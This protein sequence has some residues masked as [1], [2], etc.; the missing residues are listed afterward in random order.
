[1]RTLTVEEAD[2]V[3]GGWLHVMPGESW[4]DPQS[5][6]AASNANCAGTAGLTGV[7]AGMGVAAIAI[8]TTPVG[9]AVA[10]V[11][12]FLGLFFGSVATAGA[13]MPEPKSEKKAK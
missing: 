4:G 10:T 1:M 5:L 3:S 7:T 8:A 2:F 11:G 12:T 6:S 9:M 13:C